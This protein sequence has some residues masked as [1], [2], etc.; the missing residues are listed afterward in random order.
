MPPPG[1]P[2]VISHLF[3]IGAAT[4]AY[5][6]A[7]EDKAKQQHASIAYDPPAQAVNELPASMVYGSKGH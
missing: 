2:H 6:E 7:R 5:R 1:R 3:G 4:R